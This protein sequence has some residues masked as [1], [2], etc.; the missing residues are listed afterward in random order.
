MSTT[1]GIPLSFF[2][3]NYSLLEPLH[4]MPE[5]RLH[6][7]DLRL[8]VRALSLYLDLHVRDPRLHLLHVVSHQRQCCN[9]GSDLIHG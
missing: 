3:G 9:L 8:Q 6:A 5:V 1:L 7:R 4:L 2:D